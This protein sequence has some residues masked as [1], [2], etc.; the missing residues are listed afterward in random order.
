MPEALQDIVDGITQSV[1]PYLPRAAGAVAILLVGWILAMIASRITRRLVGMTPVNSWLNKAYDDDQRS[2]LPEPRAEVWAGKAVFWLVLVLA[3]VAALETLGSTALVAP[4]NDAVAEVLA[5]L[6]NLAGA[7]I[8]LFVAWLL[9]GLLRV[10]VKNGIVASGLDRRIAD[11]TDEAVGR[12]RASTVKL[13]GDVVFW[14]VI[15]LFLPGILGVLELGGL[16]TPAEDMITEV[17]TF[18]PNIIGAALILVVGWL[19]A[20]LLRRLVTNVSAGVGVDRLGERIGVSAALGQQRLSELI[21]VIVYVALFIPVLIAALSALDLD[22]VTEPSSEML[23]ITL[24]ALPSIFA[25]ALVLII[26]YIVGRVLRDLV[27]NMA[28]NAGANTL[29]QRIGFQ[30]MPT[31]GTWSLA[32]ILG[33]LT[34]AAFLV[35]AALEAAELLAFDAMATLIRDFIANATRVLVAVVVMG[36]AFWLARLAAEAAQRATNSNLASN[37]ARI[38]VIAFGAAIALRQ[39]GIANEII[40]LAFGLPLAAVSIAAAIAFGVGGRE[41]AR[42]ELEEWR[43]RRRSST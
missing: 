17:L 35:F 43:E 21:G 6:P 37:G 42:Q 26:A 12:D 13:L 15:L 27:V 33:S 34:L 40:I 18:V 9:A 2:V 38:V 29:P 11:E 1:G 22:A 8:L 32:S 4:V 20:K 25:A 30:A 14:V 39:I 10:L 3:G 23:G 7:M 16:L 5:F 19:V 36:L 31:E 24:S 28:E 41:T